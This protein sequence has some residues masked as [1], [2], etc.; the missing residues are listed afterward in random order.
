MAVLKSKVG[1]PVFSPHFCES[2]FCCHELSLMIDSNKKVIPIYCDVKP[3]ELKIKAWRSCS[4]EDLER[5]NRAL[6]EAK[7]RI[8]IT[9]DTSTGNWSDFLAKVSAAVKENLDEVVEL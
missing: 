1:I 4:T 6:H 9:F 7:E 2:Y 3:N 5:F 8:A